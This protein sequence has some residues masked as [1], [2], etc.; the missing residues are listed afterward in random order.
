MRF[1]NGYTKVAQI[2]VKQLQPPQSQL[3]F[4]LFQNYIT[5]IWST[6][7]LNHSLIQKVFL[8]CLIQDATLYVMLMFEEKI[9]R[10]IIQLVSRGV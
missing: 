1:E 6:L 2:V 5:W 4:C 7:K 8:F 10:K 3:M 9:L